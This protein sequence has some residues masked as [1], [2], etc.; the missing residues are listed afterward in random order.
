MLLNK[1]TI[2]KHYLPLVS[3]YIDIDIVTET[4]LSLF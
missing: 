2:Q 3:S 1:I 4:V